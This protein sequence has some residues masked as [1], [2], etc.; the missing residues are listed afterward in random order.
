MRHKAEACDTDR[1]NRES[2][3]LIIEDD[4]DVAAYFERQLHAAGLDVTVARSGY[5][6]MAAVAKRT[7][8][9]IILDMRLPDIDGLQVL[10]ALRANQPSARI[11]FVSGYLTVSVALEA[12]KLGASNVL[13]KPVSG[14]ALVAAIAAPMSV[15][16]EQPP[17]AMNHITPEPLEPGPVAQ[18][19]ALY[20]HRAYMA[21][22]DPRTLEIWARSAGS[23]VTTI[24]E[25]CRMLDIKPHDARDLARALYAIRRSVELRCPPSALLDIADSRTLRAFER[26]AGPWFNSTRHTGNLNRFL[27][28]QGFV[29][30]RNFGVVAIRVRLAQWA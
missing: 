22:L 13:E 21:S 10:T 29:N 4:Q 19:W 26:R 16:R 3:V 14:D 11:V 18:R 7:F 27:D 17:D 25:S 6:G 28:T 23:S 12:V 5:A 15:W 20:V 1:S 9:V 8:D 24:C 2:T 30:A